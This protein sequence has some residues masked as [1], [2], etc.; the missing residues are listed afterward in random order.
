MAYDA[1]TGDRGPGEGPKQF[2][3][4][5]E[6]DVYSCGHEVVGESLAR[7]DEPLDVETRTSDEP[8]PPT[9]TDPGSR[10]VVEPEP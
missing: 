10:R 8:V 6:V 7:A 3:D 5:R 4:S 1:R 2:A 9:D